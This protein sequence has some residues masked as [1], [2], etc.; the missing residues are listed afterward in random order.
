VVGR[1]RRGVGAVGR[2]GASPVCP[3]YANAVG[4]AGGYLGGKFRLPEEVDAAKADAL[5]A[6]AESSIVQML[7][8]MVAF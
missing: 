8:Q 4:P 7:A 1:R 6:A 5:R 3:A 2:G